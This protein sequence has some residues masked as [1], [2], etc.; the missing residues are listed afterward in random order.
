MENKLNFGKEDKGFNSSSIIL[1][2]QTSLSLTGVQEVYSTNE[3]LIMLKA[4]G[5]KLTITGENIN[6]T[7]LNVDTGELE[8]KGMFDTIKYSTNIKTGLFKKVFK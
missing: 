4:S 3:K 6:I 2:N 7:K 8:A 5:K 1:N